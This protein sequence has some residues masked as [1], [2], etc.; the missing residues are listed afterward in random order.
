M[1]EQ[2]G[3]LHLASTAPPESQFTSRRGTWDSG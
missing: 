3:G 2:V 1:V